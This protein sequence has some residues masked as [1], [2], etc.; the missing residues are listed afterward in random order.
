MK[1]TLLA[2]AVLASFAGAASAQTNVTIYGVADVGLTLNRSDTSGGTTTGL[3]SGIQSGSRLGFKGTEDLGGGLS[4]SFQIENGFNIDTGTAAQGG[5]LFGRQAWVGLNGGFG[6]VKFGRQYAPIFLVVDSI[7]PFGAGMMGDLSNWFSIGGVRMDNTINYSMSA[8]GFSGELAVGLGEVAGSSSGNRQ[9][10]LSVGYANGPV[11]A[12]L[13]HHDANTDATGTANLK[14]TIVGGTYNFGPAIAHLGFDSQKGN[15]VASVTDVDARNWM[16]GV[17][18]PVGAG[19][20]LASY[21]RHDDK[22]AAN[23][24]S[25]Q[26]AIGYTY[27]L[28]KRTNIHTSYRRVNTNGVSG[29]EAG[30]RHKF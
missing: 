10:G 21:V 1:K 12:Y 18:V 23:A 24:D 15:D 14:G 22:M 17:T 2:L 6:S 26:V 28:S 13:A 4:A 30:I 7:D 27:S 19:A 8:G 20:F 29:F 3:D 9:I 25:N 5:R 16:V 11:A